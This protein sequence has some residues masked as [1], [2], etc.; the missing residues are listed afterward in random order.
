MAGNPR[1]ARV[2][3]S[4]SGSSPG[5]TASRKAICPTTAVALLRTRSRPVRDERHQHRAKRAGP[6]TLCHSFATHLLEDGKDIRPVQELLGHHD[7]STT[8]IYTH[9][10]NRG[11]SAVRSP[12]DGMLDA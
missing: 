11:L 2:L 5:K 1:V 4:L 10:L 6:H 3:P 7:V 12:L 9:V 8:Q